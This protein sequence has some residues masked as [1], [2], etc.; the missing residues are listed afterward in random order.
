ME[1]KRKFRNTDMSG[2]L[3]HFT[4]IDI[5]STCSQ[6]TPISSLAINVLG[7]TSDTVRKKTLCSMDR[8]IV[9]VYNVPP[10]DAR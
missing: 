8:F 6:F 4:F 10:G 2:K 7:I 3:V 9:V 1:K 5:N